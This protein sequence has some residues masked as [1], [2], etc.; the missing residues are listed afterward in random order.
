MKDGCEVS[1]GQGKALVTHGCITPGSS[2][3][4][5]AFAPVLKAPQDMCVCAQHFRTDRMREERLHKGTD[6]IKHLTTLL[7]RAPNLSAPTV[8][9][10]RLHSLRHLAL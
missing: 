7:P 6:N 1:V 4:P 8:K 10:A 3:K 2:S 9:L 5:E